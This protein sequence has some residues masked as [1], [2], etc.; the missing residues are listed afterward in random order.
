LTACD[1]KIKYMRKR[2][3]DPPVVSSKLCS[4]NSRLEKIVDG[5]D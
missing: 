5:R 3:K 1:E 2:D 4:I